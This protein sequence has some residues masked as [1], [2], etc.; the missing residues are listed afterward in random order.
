MPF[1]N[2]DLLRYMVS[3]PRDYD[4][5]APRIDSNI[6]TMHAVYSKNCLPQIEKLL[7]AGQK[8]IIEFF[9]EVRVRYLVREEIDKYD[10]EHCSFLNI[11]SPEQLEE[12]RL[13]IEK[14]Q[15]NH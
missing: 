7:K 9:D 4:V 10:P 3:L 13:I 11:N 1:L 8:K 5:L 6:E 2:I 15:Q 12:A 14:M